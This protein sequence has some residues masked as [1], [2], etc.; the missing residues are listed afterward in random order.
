[1]P[2]MKACAHGKKGDDAFASRKCTL[3]SSSVACVEL[4]QELTIYSVVKASDQRGLCPVEKPAKGGL[5][6]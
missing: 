5:C 6:L 3:F 1:M 2:L 4:I